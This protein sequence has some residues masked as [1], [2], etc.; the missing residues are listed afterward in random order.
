MVPQ[1]VIKEK[2]LHSNIAENITV[3]N[4]LYFIGYKKL[5]TTPFA[6]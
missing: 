6:E 5:K 3:I 4:Y 2:Y 1:L